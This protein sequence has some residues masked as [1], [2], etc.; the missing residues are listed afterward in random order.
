[1]GGF[2]GWH[3]GGTILNCYSTGRVRYTG[4]T[5]PVDKG[6]TGTENAGSYTG[7]FWDTQASLQS[8]SPGTATGQTTVNMQTQST[9]TDAGWDFG[10]VWQMTGSA[11]P[12]LR[13]PG[14]V[15]VP[16]GSGTSGDPYQIATLSNL[17]WLSQ[18]NSAFGSCFIQTADV[19]AA[20]T[21]TW[22]ANQGWTPIGDETHQFTGTYDG[23]GKTI[24]GLF[25]DRV[26]NYAGFF[27]ITGGATISNLGLVG[28][29]IN[30]EGGNV[31]GALVAQNNATITN[32]YTTGTVIGLSNVGGLLGTTQGRPVSNSYS[33]CN[34]T[35]YV[36]GGGFVGAS[37]NAITNCYARGNV[38]RQV[39]GA[40][41]G[42]GGFVAWHSTGEIQ[43]CYSTGR[44]IYP[45]GTDPTIDGFVGG[46]WNGTCTGDFWDTE[47]SLQ[48][49]SSGTATGAATALMK[50][51]STF[52][53]AGWSG[54]V[55]A[56]DSGVN[57]GYPY[58]I[59]QNPSGTPLP[60]QLASLAAAPSGGST[61]TLNW[62]TASETNNY[63][64]FVQRS[65]V[66]K[67][68]FADVSALI[69]GHGTSTTGFSYQYADKSAPA[70][71]VYYRLKQVDLDNSVHYS[72]AVMSRAADVAQAAPIV[73]ALSQNYPNPFNPSTEFRFTVAK[74]GLTTLIVYNAL[75]QEV[76]QIFNGATESGKYYTA[77]LDG[78]GLASGVYFARLQSG[79]EMQ[80][81][82]IVLLK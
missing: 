15:T 72:D 59:W 76:A 10:T 27:A 61:V 12:T 79:V 82:K 5:D 64:F 37:D 28:V 70:G 39:G 16:A 44:V 66:A 36:N 22:D 78:T 55:W 4:A 62:K 45:G 42:F 60:I 58:L 32:C 9:F 34:V 47:S 71:T 21:S 26:A 68:G 53:D 43:N 17:R 31:V 48:S 65:A 38:T 51:L 50:T 81:K 69:P 25:I 23:N 6:F 75:G 20:S 54:G 13:V 7:D 56:M 80:M 41:N 14:S 73:F 77:R 67:T 30:S 33:T 24:T 2:I 52:N 11:Y 8:T 63:G 35:A 1:M 40:P 18:T 49:T 19:N 74:S 29:N 46:V 57:D 3:D